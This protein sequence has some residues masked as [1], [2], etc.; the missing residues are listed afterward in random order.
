MSSSIEANTTPATDYLYNMQNKHAPAPIQQAVL[1]NGVEY[2]H[3]DISAP[4]DSGQDDDHRS[5]TSTTTAHEENGRTLRRTPRSRRIYPSSPPLESDRRPIHEG[6][7][8]GN[9]QLAS[10]M[11]NVSV[12]SS[13]TEWEDFE[14]Q[15]HQKPQEDQTEKKMTQHHGRHTYPLQA[16]ASASNPKESPTVPSSPNESAE[17][18]DRIRQD[19]QSA[20]RTINGHRKAYPL[21]TPASKATLRWSA[22]TPPPMPESKPEQTSTQVQNRVYTQGQKTK[23]VPHRQAYPLQSPASLGNLQH[24]PSPPS[25]PESSSEYVNEALASQRVGDVAEATQRQTAKRQ[26]YPLQAQASVADLQRSS[27]STPPPASELDDMRRLDEPEHK[28]ATLAAKVVK[29]WRRQTYPLQW[30]DSQLPFDPTATYGDD[31]RMENVP[32]PEPVHLPQNMRAASDASKQPQK[33]RTIVVCLDGTGDKFDNDNSNIVHLVSALKKDD[34]NQVTYYQAGI[35]TYGEGGLSGGVYA[36]VDMAVGAGLGLHIRDAY[37]FLMV[38]YWKL[39]PSPL[40]RLVRRVRRILTDSTQHTYKEGDRICIFGFSR[41]AYT[42]RCLA[43]MVHK[44]GLLPPRN[45]QQIPFAYDFYTK[46]T[47]EG[48]RQSRDFKA[49]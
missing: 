28:A 16:P 12:E 47:L 42:A 21:Q 31:Q 24:P 44:V 27:S 14:Q 17:D 39:G 10:T 23:K 9:E 34:A 49:T 41:G 3:A 32:E 38:C 19:G 15:S 1:V 7:S 11:S 37:H 29:H 25:S 26:P 6:P 43:G 22:T 20:P 35:G 48:W 40:L 36:A 45:V 2:D 4:N 8:A 46:D 30:P 5:S 33:G 13:E 18:L